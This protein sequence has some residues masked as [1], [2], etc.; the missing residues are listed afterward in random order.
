M[1]LILAILLFTSL[2]NAQLVNQGANEV[3]ETLDLAT[4]PTWSKTFTFKNVGTNPETLTVTTGGI[5]IPGIPGYLNYDYSAR[6]D[7]AGEYAGAIP[8]KTGFFF[9]ANAQ[10]STVDADAGKYLYQ[11]YFSDGTA[12][13]TVKIKDLLAPNQTTTAVPSTPYMIK[14]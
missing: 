13:G 4:A 12:G 11:P 3:Y 14:F 9:L 10:S 7:T 2:A 1:K 6:Y 8:Y 5:R